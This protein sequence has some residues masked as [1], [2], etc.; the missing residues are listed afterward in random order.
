MVQPI[1]VGTRTGMLLR[2]SC[3]L[4]VVQLCSLHPVVR[5]Q[6]LGSPCWWVGGPGAQK[7]EAQRALQSYM[8]YVSSLAGSYTRR[9][10]KMF[11]IDVLQKLFGPSASCYRRGGEWL[12]EGEYLHLDEH[13][14]PSCP[15]YNSFLSWVVEGRHHRSLMPK[16][17]Q[18]NIPPLPLFKCL[19]LDILLRLSK[20]KF[21][22][23]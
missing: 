1:L 7:T 14:A 17:D 8:S 16:H 18:G 6:S 11:F 5:T 19:T 15:Q 21:S 13:S 3:R 20:P 2:G 10:D 9:P 23:L 12:T 4:V 22:H